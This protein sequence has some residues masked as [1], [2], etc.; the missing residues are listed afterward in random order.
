V[1]ILIMEFVGG[2]VCGAPA[3]EPHAAERAA[4]PLLTPE[5]RHAV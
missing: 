1:S 2:I 3:D 4:S 5:T